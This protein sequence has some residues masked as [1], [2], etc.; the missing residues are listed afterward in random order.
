MDREIVKA[1]S[2]IN[3]TLDVISN[4]LDKIIQSLESN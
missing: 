3:G 2:S 4:Q 1:L